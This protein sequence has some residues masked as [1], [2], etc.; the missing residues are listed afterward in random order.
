MLNPEQMTPQTLMANISL[1][2]VTKRDHP[3]SFTA[4]DNARYIALNAERQRRLDA[5]QNEA[6]DG[7]YASS[8]YREDP[9]KGL[10]WRRAGG[11]WSLLCDQDLEDREFDEKRASPPS[12]YGVNWPR[13]VVRLVAEQ[14]SEL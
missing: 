8:A 6:R 1:Y 13:A 7:I 3:E 10:L 12:M 14:D 11:K 9:E 2:H 5:A 4:E